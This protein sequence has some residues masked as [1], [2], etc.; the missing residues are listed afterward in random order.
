MPDGTAGALDRLTKR[1]LL[2]D[3]WADLSPSTEAA[4]SP[5]Q[6]ASDIEPSAPSA[7]PAIVEWKITPNG[8][9]D[10]EAV[11]GCGCW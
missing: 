1:E 11:N 10:D 3:R 8:G 9:S 4:A 2:W 6:S 7:T 5:V